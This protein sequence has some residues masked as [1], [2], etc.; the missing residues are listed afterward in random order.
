MHNAWTLCMKGFECKI[1]DQH[2]TYILIVI[3]LFSASSKPNEISILFH[4][5]KCL[6]K[7]FQ[8]GDEEGGARTLANIA[9]KPANN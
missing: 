8:F 3:I 6:N 4:M 2:T 1:T 7:L 9:A 5:F